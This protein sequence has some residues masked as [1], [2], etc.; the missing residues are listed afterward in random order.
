[1]KKIITI[2][3]ARPQFIKAATLSR[4]FKLIGVDEKIIHT[5]Q[6]FDSNMSE[7]FFS[8]MEI[9]EPAFHLDIHGLSHGAMTGRMLEAIEDILLN[10]KPEGVVVY[11]DTNSTLAGALAASKLH[12]PVVHVEA[13]LRSL[14]ME[15][16][17]EINRILT[18]RISNLLFCPTDAALSNLKSEGFDH[19]PV[20]IVKNG[21]VMQDAALYYA[22]KAEK[23]S[24]ILE[25]IPISKYVLATIHRQENTD[26]ATKLRNIVESLN[27][28]HQSIPVIVPLHPRTRNILRE[29]NIVTDFILIDPVGYFDMIMLLKNSEMVITDSGG[30]QKEAFFFQKQCITMREQ[31]EWVELVENGFNVLAGS[32][33]DK[34][35]NAFHQSLEIKSDFSLNLYGNGHASEIAAK[36]ILN[37]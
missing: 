33:K 18:D 26:S 16:P 28:I 21:D 2:V 22:Q 17:E 7:V 25:Q 29:M 31:T 12:I 8:E 23:Q 15:M 1:M 9:P 6:H 24:T 35:V 3:G 11:G 36:E 37:Y 34:I 32:D 27:V 13:G 10:E 30:V 14:N 20:K 4:Q 19:F 5:G